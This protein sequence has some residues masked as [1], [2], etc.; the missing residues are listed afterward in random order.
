MFLSINSEVRFRPEN[1]GG[2]AFIPSRSMTIEFNKVGYQI[3]E[4][5]VKRDYVEE[6]IVSQFPADK[7]EVIRQFIKNMIH[8]SIISYNSYQ[9]KRNVVQAVLEENENENFIKDNGKKNEKGVSVKY[10][11][12]PIFTWWDIT[13]VCNLHCKQCYSNSG[14]PSKNELTTSEVFSIIDQLATNRV[15]YIYFLG[16]EPLLRYDFFEIL[17]KCRE[18][19]IITMMSTNGWFVDKKNTEKLLNSG[20]HTVRVSI[21]G[22]TADVH[23]KIRGVKGSFEKALKALSILG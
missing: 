21:D 10:L 4:D 23:D 6:E 5:L 1:F 2:L 13:K 19:D 7:Q 3:L 15:F 12:A 18:K 9:S 16:G 22:A 11:S 14:R 17:R 20:I 8:S